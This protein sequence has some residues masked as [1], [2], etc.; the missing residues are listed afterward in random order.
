MITKLK[1]N[2]HFMLENYPEKARLPSSISNSSNSSSSSKRSI[3]ASSDTAGLFSVA[4]SNK[5]QQ[6]P[7]KNQKKNSWFRRK[8][9]NLELRIGSRVWNPKEKKKDTFFRAARKHSM[10]ASLGPWD[11]WEWRS[12]FG[13]VDIGFGCRDYWI[14]II[15]MRLVVNDLTWL[16]IFT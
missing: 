6:N 11:V 14:D 10:R 16:E 5:N 4:I 1:E 2:K 12:G 9:M 15:S 13:F 7:E 8:Y 3:F